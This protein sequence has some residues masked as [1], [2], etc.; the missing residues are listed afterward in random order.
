MDDVR[1]QASYERK[2]KG[3]KEIIEDGRKEGKKEG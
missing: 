3:R 2:M 1:K